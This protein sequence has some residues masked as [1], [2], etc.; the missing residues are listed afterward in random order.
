MK[1]DDNTNLHLILPRFQ[2]VAHYLF[3]CLCF[4]ICLETCC[5]GLGFDLD[6][7]DSF[8]RP[9]RAKI[10]DEMLETIMYLRC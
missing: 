2:F 4:G 3:W 9:N 5:L 6:C 1:D 10:S 7:I 8:M